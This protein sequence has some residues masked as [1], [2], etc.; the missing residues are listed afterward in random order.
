MCTPYVQSLQRPEKSVGSL[1]MEVIGSCELPCGC[2]D[3]NL[4]S[5]QKQPVLLIEGPSL[6]SPDPC[7]LD[8]AV[9]LLASLCSA[10][11]T[12]HHGVCFVSVLVS[13]LVAM[14]KHLTEEATEGRADFGSRGNHG[15]G[16]SRPLVTLRL[17][18]GS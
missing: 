6:Q 10:F 15:D 14:A 17:W 3:L 8:K 4:C 7:Y 16:N 5:L 12:N 11:Q 1:G 9:F 2:R 13:C 18:Q